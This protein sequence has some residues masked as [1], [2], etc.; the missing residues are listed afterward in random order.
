VKVRIIKR[1]HR[2]GKKSKETLSIADKD[3]TINK[4][5]SFKFANKRRD[6]YWI[7]GLAYGEDKPHV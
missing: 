6:D 3:L 4:G 5:E 7:S 2:I 1:K